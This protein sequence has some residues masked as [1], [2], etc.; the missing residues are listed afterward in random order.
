M[1]DYPTQIAILTSPEL[2]SKIV[3][4]VKPRYPDF[5]EAALL[6]AIKVQ[7]A[8]EEGT[9]SPTKAIEVAYGGADKDLVQ[10][11]LEQAAQ[12]YLRYSLQDR[13]TR[14]GTAIDFIEQQLPEVQ[15]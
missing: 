2:V 1:L 3:D 4:R 12:E 5:N 14:I 10:F 13:K 6:Q 11:V 7:R 9:G 15:G 8:I